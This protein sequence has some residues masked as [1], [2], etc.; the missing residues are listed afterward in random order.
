M[1]ATARHRIPGRLHS[2][3]V[4]SSF[5]AVSDRKD[6]MARSAGERIEGESEGDE[7]DMVELAMVPVSSHAPISPPALQASKLGGKE[8]DLPPPSKTTPTTSGP[9]DFN[10][11]STHANLKDPS[12]SSPSPARLCSRRGR[13]IMHLPLSTLERQR[14]YGRLSVPRSDSKV[15][16]GLLS[17]GLGRE[18]ADE[19][20]MLPATVYSSATR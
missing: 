6:R 9:T 18:L 15:E 2:T 16:L 14:A 10:P 11:I 19:L 8:N 12:V 1:P 3:G 7:M 13:T 17:V 5:A 4:Y 20:G